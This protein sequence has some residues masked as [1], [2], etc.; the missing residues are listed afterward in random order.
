VVD[1]GAM[2]IETTMS[3]TNHNSHPTT[4][5][6][7]TMQILVT[8]EGTMEITMIEEDTMMIHILR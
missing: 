4:T 1:N 3:H 7:I 6:M 8:M 5:T 2:M